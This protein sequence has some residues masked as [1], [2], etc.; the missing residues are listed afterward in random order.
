MDQSE[1]IK[2]FQAMTGASN[3]ESK[4][5][6][7]GHSWNVESAIS[8]FYDNQTQQT[9][10]S[11]YPMFSDGVPSTV[12]LPQISTPMPPAPLSRFPATSSQ[13]P[14]VA[15]NKSKSKTA[16]GIRTLSDINK[17]EDEDEDEENRP[18]N[19]YAGGEK[20]GQ[21]IQDPKRNNN[22]KDLVHEMLEKAKQQG[23]N[24]PE[25][26]QQGDD[27]FSGAGY[28]L[29]RDAVEPVRPIVNST[30]QQKPV[31]RTLTFWKNGFQV[32]DGPLRAIEDP[33]NRQFL[34]DINNGFVPRELNT[35]SD[36]D[37]NLVDR[38]NDDY[39]APKIK[40]QAF[41]GSG[42]SLGGGNS[43]TAAGTTVSAP[44][45]APPLT[46]NFVVQPDQPATS[47][48]IRL[49]DGTK[50]VS[51]FNLSHTVQD[52][53]NFVASAKRTGPF[54]LLTGYPQKVLDK[55]SLTIAEAGLQSAAIV[56]KL[57]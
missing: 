43:T 20:S 29:G 6:L 4:F 18:Q 32:D 23:K 9:A 34:E 41:A 19:Y 21:M 33:A 51:K 53:I 2:N 17:D 15:T 36:I 3:E 24:P 11:D 12:P 56:Q 48:Q 38:K 54:Q 37:V 42:Y 5:Y 8:S 30:A 14:V 26:L 28:R 49:A 1:A 27:K 50:L 57:L 31:T 10:Q 39:V 44:A 52:I 46:R 55:P 13:K 45:A 16:G 40:V 25:P 47:I 22:K 7:E 35:Q